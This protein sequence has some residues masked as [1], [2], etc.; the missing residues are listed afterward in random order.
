MRRTRLLSASPPAGPQAGGAVAS[1]SSSFGPAPLAGF[2]ARRLPRQ[3]RGGLALVLSRPAP[4][5][6]FRAAGAVATGTCPPPPAAASHAA[7][8][9][10]GRCEHSLRV[11]DEVI[12]A[13]TSSATAFGEVCQSLSGPRPCRPPAP[14]PCSS[15]LKHCFISTRLLPQ[16][17]QR[18][19]HRHPQHPPSPSSSPLLIA[20]PRTAA[21]P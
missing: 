9:S 6:G 16:S 17:R 14:S 21:R 8:A 11:F 5:L 12:Q 15:S 10:S 4:R 18:L 20:P 1:P 3:R 7:P 2:P 19:R 13:L